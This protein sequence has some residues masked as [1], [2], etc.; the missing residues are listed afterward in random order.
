MAEDAKMIEEEENFP[1][2]DVL[3]DD[4]VRQF[5]DAGTETDPITEA[6]VK[7]FV[8]VGTQTAPLD[9]GW[10]VAELT[11]E[12]RRR[13]VALDHTYSRKPKPDADP[14]N[15][16]TNVG[17]DS[18]PVEANLPELSDESDEEWC[19]DVDDTGSVGCSDTS[20]EEWN[21]DEDEDSDDENADFSHHPS[22]NWLA[23]SEESSN[24]SKSIVFDSCLKQL[25]QI[26]RR[27]GAIVI[28]AYLMQRGSLICVTTKCK[29][30]HTEP[31]FS[32][33]FTKGMAAG[34]L[35]CSGGILFTGNHFAGVSAVM[36]A[37]NI[38]F[39]E[40]GNFYYIQR[41]YLWPVVN[42]HYLIQQ[43]EALQSLR[44]QHL[45]L[46]GDGRCDSPGHNAKY[47]TYSVMEVTTEKIVDFSLV[48]VSEVANSNAMEKE[49]L[50]RCLEFLER[51]GQVIDLLATD[52]Y[53]TLNYGSRLPIC[54]KPRRRIP[55]VNSTLCLQR[56]YNYSVD[57][58]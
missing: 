30:G 8:H 52:R 20:D 7:T 10:A 49:G 41:K 14:K 33:P 29:A 9:S 17:P 11:P 53:V 35:I 1:L 54:V 12:R 50:K 16:T 15:V 6:P 44:G 43:K 18:L 38:R 27:C 37:C 46:A 36:S 5:A 19:N 47:G 4:T 32:Q 48:Q 39:F 26:C 56:F 40:K 21:P 22:S 23:E 34:N 58:P 42:N 55:K 2:E 51:D 24:E 3:E 57:Y 13:N 28:N 25:F 45:V 31:W